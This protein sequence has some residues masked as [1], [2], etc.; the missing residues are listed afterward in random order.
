MRLKD[1]QKRVIADL[2][3]FLDLLNDEQNIRKAYNGLWMEKGVQVGDI[4]PPYQMI[5]RGVPHICI[6]VPTGGG[7]TYIAAKAIQPI[8][9]AMPYLHFKAVVWLVPSD[10]ILKQTVNHLTDHNHPYRQAIDADFG[11]KVEV[12][13][14][15]QLLTGQNFKPALIQENLSIFIL[16]YDSFRTNRKEGRKA[17]Q[18]NG[19]LADFLSLSRNGHSNLPEIDETALIQIIRMMNPVVIVDESHHATTKLSIEMLSNF[20]PAFVLDLTATPRKQSNII[21]VVNARQ[22]KAENMVKLPVIVYNQK[23]Q[24]DVFL[25]AISLRRKL[26]EE[27]KKA[28]TAENRHIRPIVLFQAEANTGKD[29]TTYDKI[30]S[31]L[32]ASGIP[33]NQIAIKTADVDDLKQQNLMAQDCPIRYVITV[34]AL[35]EGWDCPFAYILA[36]VANRSSVVDVE[37]ILGRIL[38]MPEAKQSKRELL[39]LSYV[40]TSSSDFH[41]TVDRVIAGLENAGFSKKDKR[42]ADEEFSYHRFIEQNTPSAEKLADSGRIDSFNDGLPMLDVESIK[43][44]LEK[45]S[46]QVLKSDDMTLAEDADQ[47]FLDRMLTEAISESQSYEKSMQ[48]TAGDEIG[49]P[50]EAE[51]HMKQYYVKKEFAEEVKALEI[52]QF[53][54]KTGMQGLFG[55][56]DYE[57]LGRGELRKGFTLRDKDTQI[58]FALI[59]AEIAK[60]DLEENDDE[61]PRSFRLHGADSEE[62][63]KWFDAM[64]TEQKRRQCKDKICT[65]ISRIN[66]LSDAEIGDYVG[67]IMG[68]MTEERLTDLEQT[69]ELYAKAIKHKV[70]MLFKEH[71]MKTFYLWLEQGRIECRGNFRLRDFIRPNL[72]ITTIPKSLYEE[73]DGS[74]NNYERE[75]IENIASLENVKWWHRNISRR[76][77]KI[78]GSVHAYPD[79]L[80]MMKSGKMVMVETKGRLDADD[81][82][83]AKA[84]VE[85]ATR[86]GDSYR[87]YM[88]LEKGDSDEMGVYSQEKFMRIIK[89][90]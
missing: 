69:P 66:A 47:S 61:Q 54:L 76:E 24:E 51:K 9:D 6:K 35:K 34:N 81:V 31:M 62:I 65:A 83:K 67:R 23:S 68:N 80:V 70:E 12:Y 43:D 33:E 8:M 40:I 32:L 53:M 72:S 28:G 11:G 64:P 7:K 45:I 52:P 29:S 37:Q 58:D 27:A 1:Y 89:E 39:N 14:K 74:L 41:A 15:E 87:Y 77:F 4:I 48:E 63:R 49:L 17:Y 44:R 60:I 16:S 22:L 46:E 82:K 78:N 18:Q 42:I 71:E 55:D 57:Y 88:V 50:S 86:A 75:M 2:K 5:L 13:T 19:N 21:S 3:R 79:F 10:A 73:E 84:G 26:E 20:N 30:K 25:S 36:T 85:W 90:L 38:R 59:D 56:T